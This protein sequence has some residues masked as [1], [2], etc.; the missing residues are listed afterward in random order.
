MKDMSTATA[1][2]D[3]SAL[4]GAAKSDRNR[5]VDLY[6]AAAMVAVA[7]GHWMAIAISADAEGNVHGGNAL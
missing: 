6:R 7:V 1:T 3:L 5:A 4:A 2:P